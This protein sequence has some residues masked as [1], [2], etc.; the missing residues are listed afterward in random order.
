MTGTYERGRLTY[1]MNVVLLGAAPIHSPIHHSHD[2]LQLVHCQAL[3]CID[4]A[5]LGEARAH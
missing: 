1:R 2:S 5:D 3:I 4:N